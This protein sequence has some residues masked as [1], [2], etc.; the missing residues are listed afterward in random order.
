MKYRY[1]ELRALPRTEAIPPDVNA[2]AVREL[3]RFGCKKLDNL[4]E[5]IRTKRLFGEVEVYGTLEE[6]IGGERRLFA[7]V[8]VHNGVIRHYTLVD[9]LGVEGDGG[10]PTDFRVLFRRSVLN[11]R[12]IWSNKHKEGNGGD[13]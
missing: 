1:S 11:D 3:A 6:Q 4:L 7:T 5:H 12:V 9:T 8:T 2:G 13:E 10:R